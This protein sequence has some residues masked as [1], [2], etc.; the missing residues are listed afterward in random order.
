MDQAAQSVKSYG[1]ELSPL[2][3]DKCMALSLNEMVF[4]AVAKMT[5]LWRFRFCSAYCV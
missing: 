3:L 1:L 2:G 4:R 5:K